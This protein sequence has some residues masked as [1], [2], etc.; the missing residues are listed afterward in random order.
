LQKQAG[1]RS[2]LQRLK[3]R[4][5]QYDVELHPQKTT[6]VYCKNYLR[7]ERHEHESFTFLS[8]DF[9]PRK[10]WGGKNKRSYMIFAGAIAG[11]A[12]TAMKE[13][14]RAVLLPRWSQQTMQWFAEKLNPKIRGWI[15]YY[16][17]FYR[18][19]ML[20]L[21]FYVNER[22][23][24]WIANKHKLNTKHCILAK[25]RNFQEQQPDLFYHWRMGIKA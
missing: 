5:Q 10:K 9:Q 2:A 16:G 4:M 19:Q 21:F 22:I 8:Y 23:K 11:K 7:K 15:N 6:I 17:K 3:E 14:I 12:K 18:T 24:K 13:A 25:Y 20:K 1:S